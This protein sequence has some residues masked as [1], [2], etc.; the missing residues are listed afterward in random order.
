MSEWVQKIKEILKKNTEY[1][2]NLPVGDGVVESA[3]FLLVFPR[4]WGC[5]SLT[6]T[7]LT[8]ATL[9]VAVGAVST[10]LGRIFFTATSFFFT[11]VIVS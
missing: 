6:L 11:G 4:G 10:V 3:D 1:P 5:F 9:G 8:S 7:V 2:Y